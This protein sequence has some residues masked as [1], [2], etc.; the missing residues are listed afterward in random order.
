MKEYNEAHWKEL[1]RDHPWE[2]FKKIAEIP[3]RSGDEAALC[4]ALIGFAQQHQLEWERDASNNLL[5]R[6]ASCGIGAG[7][8]PVILQA[9]MDMVFETIDAERWPYQAPLRLQVHGDVVEAEGTSLGADNGLGLAMILSVLASGDLQHPPIEALFT[10]GEEDGLLGAAKLRRDW[11]HGTML[12]NLDGEEESVVVAGCAGAFRS[13]FRLPL[14]WE[15]AEGCPCFALQVSGL[16]GGHSGLDIH[17]D[18]RSANMLLK[19][20]LLS[21]QNELAFRLCRLSGGSRMN[22]IPTTAEAVFTVAEEDTAKLQQWFTGFW[23]IQRRALSEED[24]GCQL[25]LRDCPPQ[26]CWTAEAT[27]Q[28]LQLFSQIPNGV[29]QMDKD[30]PQ[31]VETSSNLGVVET[32]REAVLWIS[33]TRSS[34]KQQLEN[35]KGQKR[36]LAARFGA[37]VAFDS[38]Y[39]AWEYQAQS[40]LRALYMACFREQHQREMCAEVIHGGLECGLLLE[41]YPNIDA[42]SVG[43]DIQDVHS[44]SERF[45]LPSL[46]RVWA[47]LQKVLLRLC[48]I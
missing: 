4:Q 47:L 29:L 25:A 7:K 18:R 6:K 43:P 11:L 30:Q 22:A 24:Q 2:Y 37:A 1:K 32:T 16:Y 33:N 46:E 34:K 26:D 14:A 40:P 23:D 27:E 3:H 41:H 35:L 42:I 38:E 31:Y 5:I 19:D 21:L 44:V 20:A 9:H 39:P 13:E 12:L 45:S 8:P 10:T 17:K 36:E 48:S 28:A 15:N